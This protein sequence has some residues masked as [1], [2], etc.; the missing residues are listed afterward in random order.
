[1][2]ASLSLRGKPKQII[3]IRGSLPRQ[4]L[5]H[6]GVECPEHYCDPVLLLP[7]FYTPSVSQCGGISIISNEGSFW[8]IIKFLINLLKIIAVALSI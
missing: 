4:A 6:K 8:I 1:M 2:N 5:L 7:L 3:S